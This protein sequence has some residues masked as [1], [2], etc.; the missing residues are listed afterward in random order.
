[1]TQS[2]W[3]GSVKFLLLVVD[4]L[5][6]FS[7]LFLQYFEP[8][9][10]PRRW[11]LEVTATDI[12]FY[13]GSVFCY[14]VTAYSL[15]CISTNISLNVLFLFPRFFWS[16]SIITFACLDAAWPSCKMQDDDELIFRCFPFLSRFIFFLFDPVWKLFSFVRKYRLNFKSFQFLWLCTGYFRRTAGM[17][18]Y[19]ENIYMHDFSFL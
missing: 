16:S 6:S 14:D 15:I 5:S 2:Y 3:F 9:F 12:S 18:N 8:F 17:C 13:Y 19:T 10:F 4:L 7:Q 1:M 11:L